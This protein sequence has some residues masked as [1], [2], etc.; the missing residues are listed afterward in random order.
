MQAQWGITVPLVNILNGPSVTGRVSILEVLVDATEEPSDGVSA[1][2]SQDGFT[3]NVIDSESAHQLL[4]RLP[5]LSDDE[6]D[7]ASQTDGRLELQVK[8]SAYYRSMDCSLAV[9][10]RR[11]VYAFSVCH[12]PDGGLRRIVAGR[13]SAVPKMELCAMQ[14]AGSERAGSESRH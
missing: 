13:S 9:C 10:P 1:I 7:S 8:D 5:E 12:A 4:H 3:R 11:R 14:P 2:A 6:V